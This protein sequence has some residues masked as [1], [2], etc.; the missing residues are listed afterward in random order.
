MPTEVRGTDR[1]SGTWSG[2]LSDAHAT[3]DGRKR[4]AV[5]SRHLVMREADGRRL[6]LETNRD[7][8]ERKRAQERREAA[9][10]ARQISHAWMVDQMGELAASLAHEI[11]PPMAAVA[12][13]AGACLRWLD[14]RAP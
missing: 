9:P 3:R 13:S 7:I 4:R 6:V 14:R 5:E 12:A 11:E 1:A 8:T 2:E 10:T